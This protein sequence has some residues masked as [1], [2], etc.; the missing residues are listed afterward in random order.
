MQFELKT[1]LRFV[2]IASVLL[3][4][5]TASDLLEAPV[6]SLSTVWIP[7]VAIF[8]V[9][10]I[11]AFTH[12]KSHL[13]PA[14]CYSIG[15]GVAFYVYEWN[16]GSGLDPWVRDGFWLETVLYPS[17]PWLVVVLPA[18]LVLGMF[19]ALFSLS[20]HKMVKKMGTPFLTT[21][22]TEVHRD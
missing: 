16:T 19:A 7:C 13:M 18:S 10:V 2:V 1:L 20:Y 12:Q 17:M 4:V 22:S 9:G 15:A 8:V 11:G 14:V 6:L 5:V 21:E 3:W